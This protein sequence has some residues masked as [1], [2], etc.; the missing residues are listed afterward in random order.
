MEF[1]LQNS[2]ALLCALA[3][4]YASV[5]QAQ[6]PITLTDALAQAWARHPASQ[7]AAARMAEIE[8]KRSAATSLTPSSPTLALSQLSDSLFANQGRRATEEHPH[9]E[10]GRTRRGGRI[11]QCRGR[12]NRITTGFNKI[13]TCRGA[14][15]SALG[16]GHCARGRFSR[17]AQSSGYPCARRRCSV[18]RARRRSRACG[19]KPCSKRPAVGRIGRCPSPRCYVARGISCANADG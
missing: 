8:A 15:R 6:S 13:E 18:A 5:A 2:A 7:S 10:L 14:A 19:C 12:C 9:L 1:R 3:A 17:H 11:G 16:A 4:F